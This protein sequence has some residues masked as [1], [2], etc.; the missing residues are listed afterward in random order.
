MAAM[1]TVVITLIAGLA[2]LPGS[3]QEA[4]ANL[5]IDNSVLQFPTDQGTL[6]SR[7]RHRV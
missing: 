1:L 7:V 4:Q 2:P 5:C 6:R 3:V